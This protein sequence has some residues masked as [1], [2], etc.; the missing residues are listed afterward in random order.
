MT[1]RDVVQ[2]VASMFGTSVMT[3][4]RGSRRVVYGTRLKGARAALLM[5][6]LV[7]AMGERRARAITVALEAY[8]APAR[9]LDFAAADRIRDLYE[10]GVSVSALARTFRVARAT[11]RQIIDRSIYAAPAVPPWYR[12]G[13]PTRARSQRWMGRSRVASCTGWRGG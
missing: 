3:I 5:R 4:P 10:Q 12:A 8:R 1:D 2:R 11:I 6:D 9:K 13:T 7:P